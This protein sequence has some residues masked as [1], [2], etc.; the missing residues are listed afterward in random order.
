M[1]TISKNIKHEYMIKKSKFITYLQIVNDDQEAKEFIKSI[2]LEHTGANH[3]CSAYVVLPYEKY[4]DDG[5]PKGTAGMPILN[6]LQKKN[7]NN[8][9][10]CVVRYFGGIKLGAGGLIRAYSNSV[11]LALD[12][13]ELIRLKKA[14]TLKIMT[15]VKDINNILNILSNH[16]CKVNSDFENF[17]I[18]VSVNQEDLDILKSNLYNF[19]HDLSIDKTS[20]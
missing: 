14:V 16:D 2:K 8:I 4:D 10:C 19:K 15:N 13:I 11:S 1:N 5:E 9:V 17:I 18:N 7:I 3:V 12:E 20:D 6:V